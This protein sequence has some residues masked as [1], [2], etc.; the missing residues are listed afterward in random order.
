M[1]PA[2]AHG[3]WWRM[4]GYPAGQFTIHVGRPRLVGHAQKADDGRQA[5]STLK[6]APKRVAALLVL[7]SS[8]CNTSF[9]TG[10]RMDPILQLLAMNSL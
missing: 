5:F 8:S 10:V 3:W 1:L 2:R 6:H 4:E 9:V 7:E